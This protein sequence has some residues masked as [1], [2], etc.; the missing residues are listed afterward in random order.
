MKTCPRCK[1]THSKNGIFCSRSCSNSRTFSKETNIQRSKK[2]ISHF[3]KLT[4][5]QKEARTKLVVAARRISLAKSTAAR[6]FDTE[7]EQLSYQSKRLRVMIEQDFKCL[8]CKKSKWNKQP[9]PLQLDHIDGY[10]N[11]DKR[12]N[13]RALCPNCHA[14]TPTWCGKN[15]KKGLSDRYTKTIIYA[16]E[17]AENV[18]KY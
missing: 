16:K 14:L 11:N 12:T 7:F 10:H 1:D 15:N 5:E 13:V 2:L 6:L 4:P 8:E 18:R 17:I 9:I 3:E